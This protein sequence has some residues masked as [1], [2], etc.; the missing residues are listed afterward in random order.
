MGHIQQQQRNAGKTRAANKGHGER[1]G[2][3]REGG[4][5][6][7]PP[8]SLSNPPHQKG[9]EKKRKQNTGNIQTTP[10]SRKDTPSHIHTHAFCTRA[11]R[12]T[13][14]THEGHKPQQG[15]LLHTHRY[16]D[17]TLMI[18][19]GTHPKLR[20]RAARREGA[21][22]QQETKHAGDWRARVGRVC[23]RHTF[24][25]PGQPHYRGDLPVSTAPT[26][27]WRTGPG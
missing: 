1:E 22:A 11:L 17:T 16:K 8:V 25:H 20:G 3:G 10:V 27:R 15:H 18:S 12:Y 19:G 6:T 5:S 13:H 7:C 24:A 14:Q 21:R 2:E 9:V 26:R 23:C 4:R